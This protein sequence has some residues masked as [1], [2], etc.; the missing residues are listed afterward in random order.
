MV[1]NIL[2]LAQCLKE[3]L[4]A[5]GSFKFE[6]SVAR[7]DGVSINLQGCFVSGKQ[8]FSVI[9]RVLKHFVVVRKAPMFDGVIE[10]FDAVVSKK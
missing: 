10:Q 7:R 1:L 5:S 4:D 9:G 3:R 6:E 2:T 8:F